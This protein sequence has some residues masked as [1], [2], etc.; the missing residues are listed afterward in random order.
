MVTL[1]CCIIISVVVVQS[2]R[3]VNAQQTNDAGG[4]LKLSKPI[5]HLPNVT[6]FYLIPGTAHTFSFELLLL[7]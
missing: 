5:D 1:R 4:K 7:Q 2:V 3:D 6:R